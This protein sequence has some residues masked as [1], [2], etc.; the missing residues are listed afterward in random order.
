M[1]HLGLREIN[2]RDKESGSV[3]N[4]SICFISDHMTHDT[5][6]V[7]AFQK[8]LMGFVKLKL[9]NVTHVKY[10]TDGSAAQYKNYKNFCNICHHE[11]DFGLKCDWN[12]FATSHG[13]GPCDGIGGVIK[14]LATRHSKQLVRSGQDRLLNP[15][16]LYNYAKENIQG[17]QVFY[18]PTE[19]VV[20]AAEFLAPRF[21]SAQRVPGCREQHFFSPVS[22]TAIKVRRLSH[23]PGTEDM[24]EGYIVGE[25]TIDNRTPKVGSIQPGSYCACL[26]DGEWYIG[27]MLDH[28]NDND[29]YSVRFMHKS[30]TGCNFVWPKHDDICW[31]PREHVLATIET[32]HTPNSGRSY[33]ISTTCMEHILHCE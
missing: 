19:D 25:R 23:V 11:K 18:T 4:H 1:H 30:S 9:Q 17:V 29:D 28:D 2:Y 27:M 22:P 13:K 15:L 16:Q 24:L 33:T 21:N 12:F 31:V 5:N 26:Y 6:T 3:T 10:F 7:Y 20:R 14:R 32:P 8:V